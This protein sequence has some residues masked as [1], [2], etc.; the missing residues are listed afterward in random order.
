M[1][2]RGGTGDKRRIEHADAD[3]ER[4]SSLILYTPTPTTTQKV[5]QKQKGG[6]A[7]SEL[8]VLVFVKALLR[9]AWVHWSP[10]FCDRYGAQDCLA[11]PSKVSASS[12]GC[13]LWTTRLRSSRSDFRIARSVSCPVSLQYVMTLLH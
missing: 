5:P 11:V 8:R 6:G 4:N 2:V 10:F 13:Q 7:R 12:I 3:P 9:G 1:R